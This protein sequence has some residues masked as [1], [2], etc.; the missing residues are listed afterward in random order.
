RMAYASVFRAPFAIF[1]ACTHLAGF[2]KSTI[3]YLVN[4]NIREWNRAK[5]ELTFLVEEISHFTFSCISYFLAAEIIS[6]SLAPIPFG[7]CVVVLGACRWSNLHAITDKVRM[8]EYRMQGVGI[9]QV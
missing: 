5:N 4:R 3:V 6:F 9:F 8:N 2:G 1:G 7:T